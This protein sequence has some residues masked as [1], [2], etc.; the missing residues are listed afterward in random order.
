MVRTKIDKF[1]IKDMNYYDNSP[2]MV[3]IDSL[4]KHFDL[5]IDRFV[6]NG[7][8]YVQITIWSVEKEVN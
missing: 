7:I 8:G 6:K 3:I 5:D 4:K 2:Q 1:E